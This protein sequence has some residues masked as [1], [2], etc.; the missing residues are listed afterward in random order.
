[1]KSTQGDWIK[2]DTFT[3]HDGIQQGNQV[4]TLA[5]INVRGHSQPGS[6]SLSVNSVWFRETHGGKTVGKGWDNEQ[7]QGSRL[8]QGWAGQGWGKH[9]PSEEQANSLNLV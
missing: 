6:K 4:K 1:L 2:C 8:L 7:N 3:Q 9:R 5:G